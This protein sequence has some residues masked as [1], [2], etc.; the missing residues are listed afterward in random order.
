MGRDR[1]AVSQARQQ[2]PQRCGRDTASHRRHFR[3]RDA[4]DDRSEESRVSEAHG[5]QQGAEVCTTAQRS[6]HS[7]RGHI[8]PAPVTGALALPVIQGLA[9]TIRDIC[10]RRYRIRNRTFVEICRV[11]RESF[12]QRVHEKPFRGR[13]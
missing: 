11:E 13:C 2:L 6:M 3:A 8:C 9:K 10:Q 7:L 5:E 12:I 4:R 1:Y